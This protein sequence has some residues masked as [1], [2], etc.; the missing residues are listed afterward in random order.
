MV[1]G[2]GGEE[3]GEAKA[4]RMR[5]RRACGAKAQDGAWIRVQVRRTR[6]AGGRIGCQN[7]LGDV[8]GLWSEWV[9][10][11]RRG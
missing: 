9:G 6:L 8:R 11:E 2:R 10:G 7:R 3:R 1:S 4:L 5:G